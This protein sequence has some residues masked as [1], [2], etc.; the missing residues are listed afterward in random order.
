MFLIVFHQF[1]KSF[2][3]NFT[4]LWRFLF[5]G[6]WISITWCRYF[7]SVFL[8]CTEI[9]I[10]IFFWKICF[11]IFWVVSLFE[12]FDIFFPEFFYSMIIHEMISRTRQWIL[13]L[14]IFHNYL[15]NIGVLLDCL[16]DLFYWFFR[17][18]EIGLLI[19]GNT[20]PFLSHFLLIFIFSIY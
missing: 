18:T 13:F 2:I 14:W 16:I 8:L 4:F 1:F 11:F 3:S 9:K 15:I 7:V 12:K 20:L 19:L 6:V 5:F 10:S 17:L